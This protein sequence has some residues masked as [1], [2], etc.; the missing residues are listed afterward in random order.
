LDVGV[1]II[2]KSALAAV[3]LA[4]ALPAALD[5]RVDPAASNVAAKV[6]F[7]GIGSRTASFPAVSGTVRLSPA[8]MERIDLDVR[9]DARRLTASDQL[10]TDRLKG[11]NFFDVAQHPTISFVGK[12]LTMTG[13][14]TGTVAGELTA[15]GVTKPVTLAVTFTAPPARATGREAIGLTGTTTINRRDFGMTAYS[16]IVGKKV[17]ITIKTRLVPN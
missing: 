12:A 11:K 6:P 9:I 1:A 17:G 4:S 5:Y 13:P 14:T 10:T 7:L 8:A 2:I 3:L 15:R 16:L